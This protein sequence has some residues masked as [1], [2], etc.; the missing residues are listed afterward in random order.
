M[1]NY[2]YRRLHW[3][4]DGNVGALKTK[5]VYCVGFC[6]TTKIPGKKGKIKL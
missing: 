4:V 3:R 2:I 6:G 1:H 5:S